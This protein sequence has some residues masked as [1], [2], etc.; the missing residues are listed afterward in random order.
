MIIIRY[1]VSTILYI[2]LLPTVYVVVPFLSLFTRPDWDDK[3][4]YRWG[5]L[6]GTHDNPPQGDRAWVTKHCPF[7]NK[8]SGWK[9][10][11]NRVGWLYRN[12]LYNLK[13]SLSVRFEANTVKRYWGNPDISD[14]YKVPGWLFVKCEGSASWEWYSVTPYTQNRCIRI[15]LGWKIKGD[16]FSKVGDTAQLVFTINFFDGYGK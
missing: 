13:K 16:K 3:E 8:F 11:V 14:K 7:P 15:R 2:A 9:G 10:W 1:I 12:K 4:Q 6:Y 5:W